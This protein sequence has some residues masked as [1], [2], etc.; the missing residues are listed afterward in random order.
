MT[1]SRRWQAWTRQGFGD[2]AYERRGES[3]KNLPFDQHFLMGLV[4]PRPLLRMEGREDEWANPEGTS[5]TFLATQPIYD[6]LGAQT[7]NGI[8]FRKGGHEF[9]EVDRAA[10][11]RF[12]EW[13]LFGVE[14]DRS[15][16]RLVLAP[17]SLPGFIDWDAPNA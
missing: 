9:S 15:F 1:D 4:A 14:P 6:F 5:C 17:A 12:A 11:A 2:Y 16:S 3:K 10:L 8:H 13:H 7:C